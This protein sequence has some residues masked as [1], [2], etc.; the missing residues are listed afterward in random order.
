[1]VKMAKKRTPADMN[2][3]ERP[4]PRRPASVPAQ[5]PASARRHAKRHS[6]TLERAL[7]ESRERSAGLE[8]TRDRLQLES[9]I[10]GEELEL[11]RRVQR[12][13][14]PRS[15]HF[16]GVQVFSHLKSAQ[17]IG[18][19]FYD[20]ILREDGERQ[21]VGIIADVAG[22]GISA[23]LM[24]SMSIAV[25]REAVRLSRWPNMI[26]ERANRLLIDNAPHQE[27]RF[28]SVAIAAIN[29][30]RHTLSY[31]SAGHLDALLWRHRKGS[32]QRLK[33]SGLLMGIDSQARYGLREMNVEAGDRLILYT[34]G[35]TEAMNLSGEP[36]GERRFLRGIRKRTALAVEKMGEGILHDLSQF[37]SGAIIHDDRTLA[38]IEIE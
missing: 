3:E 28:V 15:T 25:I 24:M 35:I 1:M 31:S 6:A 26:L 23:A 38:I 13:F 37:C 36:Y 34:D 32:L 10:M 18:G 30:E 7:Q 27:H 14:L 8:E 33:S 16:P 9:N 19:D 20:F 22:R 2:H 4:A 11:A 21:F 17:I 5:V 12:S 29:I